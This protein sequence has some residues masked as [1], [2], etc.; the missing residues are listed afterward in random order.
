MDSTSSS[1]ELNSSSNRRRISALDVWMI[2]APL[3][4]LAGYLSIHARISNYAFV[5][6]WLLHLFTAPLK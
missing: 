1:N 4:L 5:A 2:L 3:A 6:R